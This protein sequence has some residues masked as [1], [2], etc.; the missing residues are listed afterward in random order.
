VTQTLSEQLALVYLVAKGLGHL[1]DRVVFVGGCATGLVINDD[2]VVSVRATKDVDVIVEVI[3]RAQ[4]HKL[5]KELR[6]LGFTHDPTGPICRWQFDDVLVDV[7]PDDVSWRTSPLR[8]LL[9]VYH[10]D[11]CYQAIVVSRQT[12][13]T[14]R[15][16]SRAQF[17]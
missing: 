1:N 8:Q 16:R 7:M 14:R 15:Y 6:S 3:G 4:F 9:P 17:P 13:T 2:G 11:F 12:T 5:E 10:L